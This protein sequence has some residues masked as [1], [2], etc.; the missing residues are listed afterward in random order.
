VEP[1]AVTGGGGV[2]G[3]GVGETWEG[4]QALMVE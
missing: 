1:A 4:G 3:L 2:G